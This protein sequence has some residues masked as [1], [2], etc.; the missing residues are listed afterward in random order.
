MDE[1]QRRRLATN[2]VQF[3]RHNDLIDGALRTMG[4][5]GAHEFLCECAH[6]SC[7]EMVR[8]ELGEYERVRRDPAR[9]FVRPGHELQDLERIVEPGAAWVVI[10]KVGEAGRVARESPHDTD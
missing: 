5:A 8:I 9:F 4:A 10:E 6:E 3:R 7:T 2:E 1:Q